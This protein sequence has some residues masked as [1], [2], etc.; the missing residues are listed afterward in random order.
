MP[1]PPW[2]QKTPPAPL[3]E[4]MLFLTVTVPRL[5]MAPPHWPPLWTNV[6]LSTVRVP[7][8]W[9]APPPSSWLSKNVLLCTEASP[10]L[11]IPRVLLLLRNMLF[12]TVSVPELT[13]PPAIARKL[14]LEN[15]LSWTSSVPLLSMMPENLLF[16]TMS[17]PWLVTFECP[18]PRFFR[19]TVVSGA[20][21]TYKRGTEVS[22]V[23]TPPP[24]IVVLFGGGGQGRGQRD[25]HGTRAA[26]KSDRAAAAHG[27]DRYSL[28]Q[29]RLRATRR[30]AVAYDE[31]LSCRGGLR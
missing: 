28:L 20:T 12:L 22:K 27:C 6:L 21:K 4:N 26:F 24:S 14:T 29:R 23:I 17:V 1:P 2:S 13:M 11:R 9:M 16:L 30:C 31:R 7:S 10:R 25:G 3:S 8:F 19:T 5:R 18:W 15:M